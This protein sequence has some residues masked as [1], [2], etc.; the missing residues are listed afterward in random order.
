MNGIKQIFKKELDRVFKDKKMIF[1]V[2]LLSV[3]IMVVIIS[4]WQAIWRQH[5]G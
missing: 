4:I 5:G 2:F 3:L 1:S